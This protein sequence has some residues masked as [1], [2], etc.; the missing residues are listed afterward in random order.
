MMYNICG[1]LNVDIQQMKCRV[2]GD[3]DDPSVT[4]DCT[5]VHFFV[6]FPTI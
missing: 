3:G 2:S 6:T 5:R 1:T 4:S